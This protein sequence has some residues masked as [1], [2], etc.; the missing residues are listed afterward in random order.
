MHHEHGSFAKFAVVKKVWIRP[1]LTKTA[2]SDEELAGAQ[3][4]PEGMVALG[5]RLRA[6]GRI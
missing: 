2:L 5:L 1:T 4:S 3:S 6:E